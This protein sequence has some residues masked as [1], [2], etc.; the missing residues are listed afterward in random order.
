M[1]WVTWCAAV[2]CPYRPGMNVLDLALDAGGFA[3]E[4]DSE[5]TSSEIAHLQFY[6]SSLALQLDRLKAEASGD[7]TLP[8]SWAAQEASLRGLIANEQRSLSSNGSLHEITRT[9][10]QNQARK[11]SEEIK[12]LTSGLTFNRK[13]VD[14]LKQDVEVQNKLAGKGIVVQ[15]KLNDANL[16]LIR[17][18]EKG[19][20]LETEIARA[21]QDS[22]LVERSLSTLDVTRDLTNIKESKEV[23]IEI[24]KTERQI[25]GLKAKLGIFSSET[26]PQTSAILG[27]RATYTLFRFTDGAV[28][29]GQLVDER[30]LVQRGDIILIS[31]EFSDDADEPILEKGA[32]SPQGSGGKLPIP[33]NG[34]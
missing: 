22:S 28:Q 13:E 18:E 17:A 16:D 26:S 24:A 4:R 23:I 20:A 2:L 32:A 12:A 33:A 31:A 29:P 10:L 8:A 1:L 27:G 14:I 7:D 21:E 9:S 25:E 6:R 15:D 30:T 5:T 19:L 3:K 34:P 11:I